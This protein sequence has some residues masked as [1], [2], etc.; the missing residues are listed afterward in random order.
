MLDSKATR[1]MIGAVDPWRTGATSGH[2]L[3]TSDRG[4]FVT[5]GTFRGDSGGISIA[6]R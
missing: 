2:P 4:S 1:V 6:K 3:E 5:R